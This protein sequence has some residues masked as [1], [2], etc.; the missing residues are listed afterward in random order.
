MA[1]GPV[2]VRGKNRALPLKAEI[3]D[4]G[5]EIEGGD[6]VAPP[7][8]QVLFDSGVGGAL[9]VTGEALPSG[10]G[11]DGNQFEFT[12]SGIWQFNLKTKNHTAAGTYTVTMES[13]DDAEYGIGTCQEL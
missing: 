11:T 5:F 9:D 3:F 12:T 7:V 2:T 8:I 4:D 6:I 13:G 1:S 10:Q